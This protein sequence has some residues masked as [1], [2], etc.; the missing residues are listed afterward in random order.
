MKLLAVSSRRRALA[1]GGDES[2]NPRVRGEQKP[3][4]P[5]LEVSDDGSFPPQK[6]WPLFWVRLVRCRCGSSSFVRLRQV[7][8]F[9]EM[10]TFSNTSVRRGSGCRIMPANHSPVPV[11]TR[12]S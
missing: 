12:K 3:D 7:L 6:G 10:D 11:C 9:R 4:N 8:L 2:E 1:L 5:A